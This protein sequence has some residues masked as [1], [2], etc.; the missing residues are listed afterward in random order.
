MN[1]LQTPSPQV[2]SIDDEYAALCEA[3]REASRLQARC[4]GEHEWEYPEAHRRF[5]AAYIARVAMQEFLLKNYL[6][7]KAYAAAQV[8]E[9]CGPTFEQM[10]H[11]RG[12][13]KHQPHRR[14]KKVRSL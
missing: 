9:M 4:V 11:D 14:A 5:H 7:D 6:A 10:Q 13:I 2:N 3:Q 8:D 1:N 12:I